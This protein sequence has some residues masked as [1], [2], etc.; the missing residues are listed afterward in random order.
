MAEASFA[1][2]TLR[3]ERLARAL[4]LLAFAGCVLLFVLSQLDVV[5]YDDSYFFK[6]VAVHG[7]E[8]GKL[9]WNVGHKPVYGMTSLL[10]QWLSLPVAALTPAHFCLAM[11][12]LAGVALVGTFALLR[13][14]TWSL[15]QGLCT[16]LLLVAPAAM[17]TTLSGMETALSLLVIALTL[18][19]LLAEHARTLPWWSAPVALFCVYLVRP[20]ALLLVLGPMLVTRFLPHKRLP[21]RELGLLAVLFA[22]LLIACR[23]YFGTALPLPFYAKQA[24][25]SPYDAAFIAGSRTLGLKRF[26]VYAC[27]AAPGL[28]LA[29]LRRDALNLTLVGSVLAHALYHLLFTVDIMGMHGRFYVPAL[30]VLAVAGARGLVALHG[31]PRRVAVA[32]AIALA[33]LALPLV[34]LLLHV[35]LPYRHYMGEGATPLTYVAVAVAQALAVALALAPALRRV[36][37]VALG[38]ALLALTSLPALESGKLHAYSDEDYLALHIQQSTVNRGIDSVR[39]CL[40]ESVHVY[41]SE[42]GV[43]SLRFLHG[44]VTDTVGLM[45]RKWLFRKPGSFDALCKHDRPEAIFMPHRNYVALNQEILAGTCIRG[46]RRMVENSKSPLYV[47]ND[48]AGPFL[49]CARARHDPFVK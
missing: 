24:S 33:S 29:L 15:D 19:L 47:R 2:T 18:W 49:A 41:H 44:K 34:A 32:L 23:L 22:L 7:L 30:P 31:H 10:Y 14:I 13:R 6:R 8:S 12:A 40:G 25:L 27:F 1:T 39:A 26:A 17:F 9:A 43:A 45:S 21:L 38:F 5:P 37:G 35:L 16:A 4:G 42:I 20:D 11:R 46:Y 48:L 36:W 28:I 3:S